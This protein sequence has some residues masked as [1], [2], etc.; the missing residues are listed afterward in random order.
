MRDYLRNLETGWD[1]WRQRPGSLKDRAAW[2]Y[3][4]TG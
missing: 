4:T 3:V 1:I 2:L